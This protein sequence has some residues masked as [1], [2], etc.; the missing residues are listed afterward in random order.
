MPPSLLHLVVTIS[1]FSK[2]GI[3]FITCNPT[4]ANGHGHIVVVVN[5]FT[6]WEEA[7]YTYKVDGETSTLF[8]FNQVIRHFGVPHII[9]TEH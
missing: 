6:K 3:D 7:I 8:L 4:L 2:W 9:V 5:N 1:P